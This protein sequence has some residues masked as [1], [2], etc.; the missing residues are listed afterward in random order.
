MTITEDSGARAAINKKH[1]RTDRWWLGP[2]ITVIGLFAW[3]AYAT[4]RVFYQGNYWVGDYHYL[5]PFYSPCVS[6]G[7]LPEASLFGRILP[8]HPLLP[9]AALSLPLLLMF[10]MTC[11]Y[12]RKAYY[13]SVWM[14][15]AACGVPDGHASYTGETRFPLIWQNSH[16]YFFYAALAITLINTWDAIIAFQSPAGFGFGL[17]N[18]I[19]VG[20]VILLWCYTFGCHSCRHVMGGRIRHFSQN[21]IRYKLWTISSYLNVRHMQFA[22]IT[23]GSLALTDFYIMSVSAGWITDLRFIN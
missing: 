18:I 20:N 12:Y 4:F 7:C 23:L 6:Q 22:W 8:D 15:P 5:T 13:R 9:Y 17:G 2:A 11:Y 19:L 16:R 14:A 10:R 3:V 21:P 1:L